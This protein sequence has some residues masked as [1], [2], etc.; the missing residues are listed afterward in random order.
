MTP[1]SYRLHNSIH[2][3]LKTVWQ[4]L[5]TFVDGKFK[6]IFLYCYCLFL[7]EIVSENKHFEFKMG[8]VGQVNNIIDQMFT[9]AKRLKTFEKWP[10]PDTAKCSAAK[11]S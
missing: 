3:F 9:E 8:S 10:L 11:V 1:V 4:P 2:I 5:V 7:F 6:W